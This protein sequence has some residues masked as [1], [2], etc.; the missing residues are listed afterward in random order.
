M[1]SRSA[2]GL[3]IVSGIAVVSLICMISSFSPA[4]ADPAAPGAVG[5]VVH[6]SVDGLRSDVIGILGPEYLPNFHRMRIA[7]IYTDNARTDFD[8]TNTLPNHSCM[9]TARPVLG[10]DG[11]GVSFNSDPG[12]TFEA[13]NGHY[14]AGVFDVLHDNGYSTGMYASKSKFAFFERSWDGVNGAPDMIGADDGRNKMDI[15]VNLADTR[16]LID[17]FVLHMTDLPHTYSFVHITDPDVVGHDSGWESTE[18]YQSVMKVDSLLGRIFNLIDDG[19]LVDVTAVIVTADHGGS[20][21]TH[22]DPF[23]PENY[24]VPLYVTGPGVP[25]GYDIYAFNPASRLDPAGSRPSYDISPQPVRNGGSCNLALELLGLE[26]IP[27]SVI[28]SDQDLD[29]MMPNGIVDLPD[30]EIMNPA[31][32]ALFD[33]PAT[34]DIEAVVDGGSMERV[35]FY[36]GWVLI[37]EDVTD[38]YSCA[39]INVLPGEYTVTAKALRTD[40]IAAVA[41][42]DLQVVSITGVVDEEQAEKVWVFPNPVRG[43]STVLFSLC[44]P[45]HVE[46][47]LYDALGRR[48]DTIVGD[49][50][51]PGSHAVGLD[52]ERFAPGFYFYR[53]NIGAIVSSGKILV[54]R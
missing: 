27:G 48:V 49:F 8:F 11:H 24:T 42:I 19:P 32:G 43:R 41:R 6:V 12:T 31:D 2:A 1:K 21:T 25:A 36:A 23:L 33:A 45:E 7:G 35:E 17:S 10:L 53:M 16:A 15:Y 51:G 29:V 38:P 18:Y 5:Y 20:G 30:V 39:W 4:V 46:M 37:G 47:V 52:L 28:N 40:G 9:L 34:I 22:D 54:L 26:R 50:R 44:R 14:I 13:V 3:P